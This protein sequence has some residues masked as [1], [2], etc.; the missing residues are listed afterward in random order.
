LAYPAQILRLAR[1]QGWTR[2]TFLTLGKLAE[3]QGALG[4][5]WQRLNGRTG[6][7]IEYK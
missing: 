2:A 5:A 7:L 1:R 6:G 3:A 4:Y